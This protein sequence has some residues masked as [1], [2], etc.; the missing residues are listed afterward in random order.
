MIIRIMVMIMMIHNDSSHTNKPPG[1]RSSVARAV[2]L[3]ARPIA[4]GR[5]A[6]KGSVR[7]RLAGQGAPKP[8]FAWGKIIPQ[9]RN[10]LGSNPR[11][12]GFFADWACS[13]NKACGAR[14]FTWL[15]ANKEDIRS[16]PSVSLHDAREH[17]RNRRSAS[18]E[19]NLTKNKATV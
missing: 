1:R 17:T 11:I 3:L 19:G 12:S 5:R 6:R 7:L 18:V 9:N 15:E 16:T 10:L 13:Q 14:V 8:P 4:R 2:R